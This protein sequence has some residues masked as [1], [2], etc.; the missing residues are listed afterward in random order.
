MP[1]LEVGRGDLRTQKPLSMNLAGSLLCTLQR[2]RL[3]HSRVSVQAYAMTEA[4]HQ[5]TSNPLPKHGPH[6]PGLAPAPPTRKAPCAQQVNIAPCISRECA[7][8]D[9]MSVCCYEGCC[10]PQTPVGVKC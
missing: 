2:M 1:V 8:S 4:S 6:K 7:L 3:A 5:M 10:R 9:A